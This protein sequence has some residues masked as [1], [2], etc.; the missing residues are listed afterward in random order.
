VRDVILVAP[1]LDAATFKT[2]AK[3]IAG[4]S[5]HVTLYAAASDRAL[6]ISRRY[7][8]GTPRAGDVPGGVP[9]LVPGVV[10]IDVTATGTQAVGLNH[11][12]YMPGGDLLADIGGRL[13]AGGETVADARVGA[14]SP[15]PPPGPE[16]VT[17]ANGTFF[18][19][20]PASR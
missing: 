13:G 11:A 19:Y 9:L 15:Q 20:A 16:T 6:N 17:T 1:D 2:R 7:T 14:A 3:E 8:G 10:S 12:R 4:M 18:R 5:S